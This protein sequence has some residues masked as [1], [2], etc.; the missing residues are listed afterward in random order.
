MVFDTSK[1]SEYM[2]NY[3]FVLFFGICKKFAILLVAEA[4]SRLLESTRYRRD[5]IAALYYFMSFWF[6]AGAV[7]YSSKSSLGGSGVGLAFA[8]CI[9]CSSSINVIYAGCHMCIVLSV[10]LVIV[11]FRYVFRNPSILVLYLT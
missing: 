11:Q 6:S 3:R 7:N 1:V 4:I 8:S 9:L 5:P 10:D 2:F